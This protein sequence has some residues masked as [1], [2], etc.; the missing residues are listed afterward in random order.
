MVKVFF[1]MAVISMVMTKKA[2]SRDKKPAARLNNTPLIE[3]WIGEILN[4]EKRKRVDRYTITLLKDIKEGEPLFYPIRGALINKN[5]LLRFTGEDAWRLYQD[6]NS[7]LEE[8]QKAPG[9][10]HEK[11]LRATGTRYLLNCKKRCF[12]QSLPKID[13]EV[14]SIPLK[15]PRATMSQGE[16]HRYWNEQLGYD[17]I[18]LDKKGPFFLAAG[19]HPI[20][21]TLE[22]QALS[23]QGSYKHFILSKEHKNA[24]KALLQA[25]R[26]K[27]HLV[28]FEKIVGPDVRIGNKLLI[29]YK[30]DQDQKAL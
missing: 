10:L 29:G 9:L 16:W 26:V 19:I 7:H 13:P 20:K 17:G 21:T 28:I 2:E 6:Q 11:I 4:S 8:S 27:G 25:V 14:A 15:K 1:L 5:T 23:Y 3:P 30:L 18:I 24:K 22:T 12:L